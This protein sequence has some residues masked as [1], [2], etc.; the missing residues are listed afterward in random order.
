MST[1]LYV[2]LFTLIALACIFPSAFSKEADKPADE[3]EGI[4]K[5][6]KIAPGFKAELWTSNKQ[7]VNPVAI[8]FDD[9]N[10]LYVCET[11]RFR[12]GGGLDIREHKFMYY[13]DILCKTPADRRANYEK[14]KDKFKPDYFTANKEKIVLLEDTQNKGK[15]DKVS[16]F[17][18]AFNDALDGPGVGL[19]WHDGK[20]YYA[21][22]PKIWELTGANGTGPVEKINTLFDGFGVRVSISGHDCHGTI[23]GPDGKLYWSLGDRGYNATGREG[24]HFADPFSGGVFRANLDGSDLELYYRG[25]RNPQELAFDEFGN[26]FTVDNNADIGDGARLNYIL[27][28]GNTGWHMGWQMLGSA[29]FTKLAGIGEKKP[30][31]W[32]DEGIWKMRFDMQTASILPPA[33]LITSGP[34]GFAYAPGTG[35]PEKYARH[36]FICDYSA[37]SNS[38]VHSFTAEEEG[39]GFVMKNPEKFCW[40]LT[41]TDVAFGYDGRMYICDYGGGWHLS[42][43]GSIVALGDPDALKQ[44]VVQEVR[45]LF[46]DGIGK[47]PTK[48]LS[49]LLKHVDMRVRQRAQFELAK[50]GKEGLVALSD[51]AKTPGHILSRVHGIWG[52]GQLAKSQPD[53]LNMLAELLG[54]SEAR[55]REQAAKT[56]GDS[57]FAPAMDKLLTLLADPSTRV[58]AFAAIA[59]SKLKCT[60]DIPALIDILRENADKDPYLRHAA[61]MGLAGAGDTAALQAHAFDS[62]KGV[63]LGVLLALRRMADSGVAAFLKDSDPLIYAEAIRAIYDEPVAAAMPQLAAEI[64]RIV[65]TPDAFK[66]LTPLLLSRILNAN[67]RYGS[68]AQAPAIAEFAATA[69]APES[70]R[71]AALDMLEKWEQPTVVDPVLGLPRPMPKREKLVPDVA[72]KSAIQKIM[73]EN[74]AISARAVE[75]ALAFGVELSDDMLVSFV[76][77]A[78]RGEDVRVASLEQLVR[79]KSKPLA[80]LLP[81]LIADASLKVRVAG[82]SALLE[83]D[84]AAGIKAAREILDNKAPATN[85]IK[86]VSDRTTGDWGALKMGAPSNADYADQKS[87]HGAV[88]SYVKGFGEPSAK[89]GAKDGNLPRLNDGLAAEIDDDLDHNVWI[90]AHGSRMLCDLQKSIEIGAVN[91]FSWHVR[92]R[93]PQ[94]FTLWGS[95]K[96]KPDAA[97]KELKGDWTLI[98]S[99]DTTKLND[100]GKHGSMIYNPGGGLGQFRYLLWQSAKQG[101]GT[102]FSEMDVYEKGKW[103]FT[104]LGE[105]RVQQLV[106]ALLGKSPAPAAADLLSEWIE[107]MAAGKVPPVLHLDLIEAAET[108]KE[109]KFVKRMA[110]F[111]KGFPEADKLASFRAALIG[112]DGKCGEEIFQFHAAGCLKCHKIG[113]AGHD[114][115]SDVGPPLTGVASRLTR[116]KILESLLEPSAV[117]V[118]GY[119][120]T[121]FKMQDGMVIS[122][123]VIAENATEITVKQADGK[124]L[125]IQTGEIKK[126]AQPVSPMPPMGTVLKPREM[127]DLI[128]YLSTLK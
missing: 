96:D 86:V 55:V 105:Y 98:A 13:D 122:G 75:M 44:P 18:E 52:L 3:S 29:D 56:I 66:Q 124:V 115:G 101:S 9:Q 107:K 121:T 23:V 74:G 117:I 43:K 91:T 36:F 34:C 106:F 10:R 71:T 112:G 87:G 17:A 94:H 80:A 84:E 113:G 128:E 11:F 15:A 97:A 119:G 68:T 127:R 50:R 8:S 2:S 78:K 40:G 82:L 76:K 20:L 114:T 83:T 62:S 100:G 110:E 37:G 72:I 49:A 126:R 70:V 35:L 19:A 99:V 123:S 21:C 6:L 47:L 53:A 38:G 77:N 60:S 64:K 90:D 69:S 93:A 41:A 116:E 32:M 25:L 108:R 4:V 54:D 48:E 59:L 85:E 28:G 24:Q 118:P 88:F 61:V 22:V 92:D 73:T 27:E 16:V 30:N 125:K 79:K 26:L 111:Q 65:A 95:A 103:D 67:Y 81:E 42:G 31:P 120:S 51:A 63:R 39:A 45:K 7:L 12:D 109:E 33:G 46:A 58:R 89:S 1:R 5:G 14:Y 104:P 102:F 57:R